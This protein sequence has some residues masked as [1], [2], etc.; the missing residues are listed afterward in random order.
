MSVRRALVLAGLGVF[1]SLQVSA[2]EPRRPLPE[3]I[4]EL[5]RS[6]PPDPKIALELAQYGPAAVP[7]LV[8]L[9]GEVGYVTT[10]MMERIPVNA[11]IP[12]ARAVIDVLADPA[13]VPALK[14]IMFDPHLG[15]AARKRLLALKAPFAGKEVAAIVAHD[16]KTYTVEYRMSDEYPR[17]FS[18]LAPDDAAAL[19]MDFLRPGQEIVFFDLE[20]GDNIHNAKPEDL[21]FVRD[22]LALLAKTGS[23]AAKPFLERQAAALAKAAAAR[24]AELASANDVSFDTDADRQ[25]L[26][27]DAETIDALLVDYKNSIAE[28]AKPKP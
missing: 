10:G 19:L 1:S 9:A 7:E 28:L 26:K 27:K 5:K 6:T 2:Q 4:A 23:P 22:T 13:A 15:S 11:Y 14:S 24:R 17:L 25:N 21:Q 18:A 12:H 16:K 8:K 3:L 20:K